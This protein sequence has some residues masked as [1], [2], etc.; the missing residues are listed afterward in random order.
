MGAGQVANPPPK[1]CARRDGWCTPL[2]VFSTLLHCLHCRPR[3]EML[4]LVLY[5]RL[6]FLSSRRHPGPWGVAV[7]VAVPF[8][9]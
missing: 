1:Q 9:T 7:V 3:E 2:S 6:S 8:V 4:S 5:A